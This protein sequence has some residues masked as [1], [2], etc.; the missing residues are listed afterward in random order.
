MDLVA[1]YERLTVALRTAV[2]ISP[3]KF[4]SLP[5]VSFRNTWFVDCNNIPTNNLCMDYA[6]YR[7]S[8]WLN[9]LNFVESLHDGC[10][11]AFAYSKAADVE[12]YILITMIAVIYAMTA[13]IEGDLFQ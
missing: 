9:N 5:L 10:T 12:A 8:C 3:I 11:R 7:V 1:K 6:I 13:G 2:I 4:F